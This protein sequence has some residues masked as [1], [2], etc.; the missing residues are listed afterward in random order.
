MVGIKEGSKDYA[1]AQYYLGRIAF[2]ADR[3]EEALEFFEEA[4]DANEKVAEYHEWL[5]NAMG[6]VARDANMFR[7]GMLA[8]KMKSAWETAIR[9]DPKR[10]GPRFSLIEYYIQAPS[11]VGGSLEKAEATAREIIRLDAAAGHRALGNVFVNQKKFAEAEKEY[12]EAARIN[13]QNTA[14]LANFY[15]N[16]NQHDKAFTLFE[17]ALKKNPNDMLAHYQFGK[18]AALS[19][20]K[21]NEGEASLKKYLTYQPAQNEPSHAGAHMRLAQINEKR[22]N[23]AEAKKLYESALKQDASLKEAK[24]GLERVSK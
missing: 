4:V 9:L 22:G 7:Q 10:L 21:L 14:V 19:G 6:S 12:L 18:T 13:P 5:G 24:E 1:E 8:P 17:E 20:K 11:V 2:D 3:Y 15:F 23:K 16:Q